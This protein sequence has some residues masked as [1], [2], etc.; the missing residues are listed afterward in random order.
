MSWLFRDAAGDV[1]EM[2]IDGR[3]L[4]TH[5]ESIR[6]CALTGMGSALLPDWL[7]EPD[8]ESGKLHALFDQYE[9]TATDYD[10]AIWILQP[11]RAMCR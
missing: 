8:I 3:C 11:S 7:V 9:V 10:S 1:E 5:P 4:I 6:Q 2:Q